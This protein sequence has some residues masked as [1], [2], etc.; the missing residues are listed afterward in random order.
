M[1]VDNSQGF[2]NTNLKFFFVE[3]GSPL[4]LA[5]GIEPEPGRYR[6]TVQKVAYQLRQR[7]DEIRAGTGGDT[8]TKGPFA[9]RT[10]IL[11]RKEPE[12]NVEKEWED[13]RKLLVN[14]GAT[15]IPTT[16]SASDKS[17]AAAEAPLPSADL[18][19]QLFSALDSLDHAKAEFESVAARKSIRVLQ[20]RKK[21]P[22]L[23]KDLAL[24][25]ALD[26]ADRRFCEGENVQTG[27][28]EDFKVAIRDKLEKIVPDKDP[29]P[30]PEKPYLYITADTSDLRLARALQA[31]ARKRTVAVVMEE[32]EAHRREDF[33]Q[34]LLQA[35]GVVFLHGNATRQFVDRWLKEFVKKTR[36]LKIH[37]KVAALYQAPPEKAEEDEPLVPIEELRIEGSQKEFTLQGIEKICA[38]LC[39]DRR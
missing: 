8:G 38:E 26:E 32:D 35:S 23:K 10:V 36:L 20:W 9:G 17:T 34:G 15:V 25:K 28:L 18:F 31:A 13:I 1:P 29:T 16:A 2:W 11:A 22:D 12:S 19:V 37:P 27:L 30:T 7:L 4:R 6:R 33:E 39:G 14:D 24:L 3:D 21:L 5:P